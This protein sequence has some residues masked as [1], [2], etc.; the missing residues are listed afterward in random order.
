MNISRVQRTILFCVVLPSLALYF[1]LR[2]FAQYRHVEIY[3]ARS[4]PIPQELAAGLHMQEHGIDQM[5]TIETP[6][7]QAKEKK[8]SIEEIQRL[9][10]QIAWSGSMPAFIDSLTIQSPTRALARRTTSRAM[11]EYQLVRTGDQWWIQ[12]ATRSQIQPH[13]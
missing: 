3:V 4:A 2:L 9:R 12:D 10:S 7:D 11:L 13:L 6:Y 5:V 1:G 8:L